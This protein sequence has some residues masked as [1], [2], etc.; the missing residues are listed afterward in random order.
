VEMVADICRMMEENPQ[1]KVT[2]ADLGKQFHTSPT[3]L[4]KVFKRISGVTPRQYQQACRFNALRKELSAG[5]AVL[6]A[7]QEAGFP[8]SSSVYEKSTQELGMPPGEYA[9]KGKNS[10]I[11]Y[12][13]VDC[14]LGKLLVAGTS[15][16]V[17]SVKL[18]DDSRE[19]VRILEEEFEEASLVE[20]N[21]DLRQ[22]VAAILEYLE[23]INA[24]LDLPLDVRGTLF[25]RQVWRALQQIP[26]GSTSSYSEVAQ[27][28]GKTK[29]VRAVAGACAANPTA[30]VVPCHR[31]VRSDGGLGGY[32][33]G[34]ERKKALLTLEKESKNG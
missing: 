10:M 33:W 23:G 11:A 8:S 21:E 25:Q 28:I 14:P 3:H 27:A 7:I 12:T 22:W 20:D 5:A 16:G 4:Q 31:V 13:V 26:Y 30:L 2:L 17:C 29:A 34:I 19:L 9:R 18:G 24:H 15:Q 6:T 32:H 1:N